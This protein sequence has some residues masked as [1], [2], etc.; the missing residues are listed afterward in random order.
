[1]VPRTNRKNV[2]L[3]LVKKY[4]TLL[5][6]RHLIDGGVD[7]RFLRNSQGFVDISQ[8]AERLF[9]DWFITNELVDCDE[10]DDIKGLVN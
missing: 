3:D 4:T 2:E 6:I 8:S 7:S 5:A 10:G 9:D 1:M